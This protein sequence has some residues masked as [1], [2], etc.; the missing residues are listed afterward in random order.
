MQSKPYFEPHSGGNFRIVHP[1][2]YDIS[3]A[4]VSAGSSAQS[5]DSTRA[6]RL[7]KALREYPYNFGAAVMLSEYYNAAGD[8]EAACNVRFKAAQMAVDIIPEDEEIYLDWEYPENRDMCEILRGSTIDHFLISD[9]EMAAAYLETLLDL[10][11]E[12]HLEVTKTLAYCYIALGEQELFESILFD[13]DDKDDEKIIL[14]S[15]ASQKFTG[16]VAPELLARF[17]NNK[18]LYA[19]FTGSDHEITP[20]Y[21]ADIESER[22]SQQAASRLLWLRTEHIWNSHQEFI[23]MLRG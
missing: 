16:A 10:D 20:E 19:E 18:A 3:Q 12:D 13:I 8:F 23:E 1:R 11:E 6:D 5:V 22:P 17:K 7:K 15:W 2:T 21:I 4:A 14:E 9:F